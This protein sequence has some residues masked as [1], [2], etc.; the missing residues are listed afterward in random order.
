VAQLSEASLGHS[1]LEKSQARPTYGLTLGMCDLMDARQI[2]LMVTGPS[3][4][5]PLE[6]LLCG[7]ITTRF[8]A[9]M[10]QMHPRVV[11]LCDS[12]ASSDA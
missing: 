11:L 10:L 12:T 8:P 1:M 4:R 7:Q 9:T 2:L 3:K 5:Q 6:R